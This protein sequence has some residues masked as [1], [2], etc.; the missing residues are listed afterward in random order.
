MRTHR[1]GFSLSAFSLKLC[2][3][4]VLNSGCAARAIRFA[5]KGMTCAEA[6]HVAIAAV[7][8]MG[9]MVTDATK[10]SP[11]VPGVI[12]AAR[13]EGTSTRGLLVQVFCTTLGVEIEAKT[14][15]GGVEQL[16]FPSEF[17]RSFEAAAANRAPPRAAA[18]SGLDVLLT[19]E[20]ASGSPEL[21]VDLT[22]H[23]VLPVN[24]RITNRSARTYRFRE[25]KVVLRSADGKR[26]KPLP[27]ADVA[28]RLGAD[29]GGIVRQKHLGDQDIN[30][31]Q[32][33]TG[34]LFFP[35]APYA[36]AHVVLI[37]RDSGEPE[38]FS[39]EF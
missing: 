31:D 4:L 28:A 18:A 36:S 17:K 38:G 27:V 3:V 6:N 12:T 35:F 23:D 21:A 32:T 13:T 15:Q 34:F 30:P 19:P 24:V 14:D 20:R 29:T 37:D 2:V 8:R 22:G 16:S 25:K 7:Q 9:Y 5:E 33:L 11:G 1:S 39:I 10:P 26:V